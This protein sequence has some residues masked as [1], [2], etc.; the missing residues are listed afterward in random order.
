VLWLQTI[1]NVIDQFEHLPD[2][3]KA[4]LLDLGGFVGDL[5]EKQEHEEI[6]K[7]T[8][9][10]VMACETFEPEKINYNGTWGRDPQND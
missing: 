5:A 6:D 7:P 3:D 1:N 4:M 10:E 9:K 2:D 8:T